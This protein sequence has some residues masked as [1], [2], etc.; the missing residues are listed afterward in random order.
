LIYLQDPAAEQRA[1][2]NTAVLKNL[3]AFFGDLPAEHRA[4]LAR[5]H[6]MLLKG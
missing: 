4:L 3:L 5:H 2:K 1:I 6:P